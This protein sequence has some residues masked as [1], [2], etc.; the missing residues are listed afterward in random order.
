MT[1]AA[2]T[3]V[4]STVALRI[5]RSLRKL[6]CVMIIDCSLI[7]RAT[8]A[9]LCRSHCSLAGSHFRRGNIRRP[10]LQNEPVMIND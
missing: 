7:L 4:P 10:G 5:A 1:R 2:S 6:D 3:P 9:G 8:V